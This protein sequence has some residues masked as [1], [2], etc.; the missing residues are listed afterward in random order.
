[1]K[2]VIVSLLS[3][4]GMLSAAGMT[5]RWKGEAVGQKPDGTPTREEFSITLEQKGETVT[6]FVQG[7]P[8]A[9]KW[10]ILEGRFAAD[11][12]T[13]QVRPPD[14]G[15]VFRISLRLEGEELKGEG[16]AENENGLNPAQIR[17]HRVK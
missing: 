16:V 9:Q 14:S 8:D 4:L 12:L 15:K 17:L 1:M 11:R 2:K 10:E 13:F 3:M 5:G 7:A 6:G